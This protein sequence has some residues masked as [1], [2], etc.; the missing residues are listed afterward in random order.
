MSAVGH[1]LE[2]EGIPTVGIS[3]VREHSEK[4]RPPRALWV[5]FMLGR[6]LG[7][8]DAPDFQRRVLRAALELLGGR[9]GGR[10]NLAQGGGDRVERL[11]EALAAAA[12]TVRSRA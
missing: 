4:I 11:D 12:A 5:P 8:P 7:A 2:D 1:Y 10:G 9:G 3:L 6:P